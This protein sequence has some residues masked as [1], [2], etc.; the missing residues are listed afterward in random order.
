[1]PHPYLEG[2]RP[3]LHISHRGGAALYPENTLFAFRKA[4]ELHRTDMIELDVHATRDGHVVVAHDDTVDRCTEATGAIASFTLAELRAL[5]AGHRFT[6]DG[7]TFPF[8]GHRVTVPLLSEVLSA[9]PRVRINVEQ[10]P[11]T[12]GVEELVA[13]V[14]R[15]ADALD[16]VCVGSENDLVAERLLRVLPEACHFYPRMALTALVLGAKQ[17]TVPDPG[18][19]VVLDMPLHYEGM[20]LVDPPFLRQMQDIGRWVNV[21]TIDDPAEMRQL[22]AEGVGGI[23]TDRPDVLRDVLDGVLA[24]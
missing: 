23:M 15:H 7:M 9:L 6:R 5:D 1:M 22:V 18:P 10:K 20:R 3:T 4:A 19:Y 21:W 24:D 2:L 8:R 16:R 14:L 17:G 12:E 11:E 13:A